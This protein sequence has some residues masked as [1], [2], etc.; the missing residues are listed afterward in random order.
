M[1][2]KDTEELHLFKGLMAKDDLRCFVE[3]ES[4]CEAMDKVDS[5]HTVFACL[6]ENEARKECASQG[7]PVCGNCVKNLYANY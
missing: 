2:R 3:P 6:D 5:N 4:I 1:K 7:R